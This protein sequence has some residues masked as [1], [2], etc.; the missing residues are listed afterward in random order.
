MNRTNEKKLDKPKQI[1]II[2]NS[3]T[4]YNYSQLNVIKYLE[5]IF[6]ANT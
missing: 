5:V 4:Y 3:S 2:N 1:D 6:E